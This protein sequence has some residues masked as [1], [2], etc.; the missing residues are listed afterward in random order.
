MGTPISPPRPYLNNIA[1]ATITSYAGDYSTQRRSAAFST[2][3]SRLESLLYPLNFGLS[4]AV[5]AIVGQDDIGP[6]QFNSTGRIAWI[7]P[8]ELRPPSSPLCQRTSRSPPPDPLRRACLTRTILSPRHSHSLCR[9]HRPS[10]SVRRGRR[11]DVTPADRRAQPESPLAAIEPAGCC[12][13][14]PGSWIAVPV[15]SHTVLISLAIARRPRRWR[16]G[17]SC[18]PAPSV[19]MPA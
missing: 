10:L 1:L 9:D 14:I 3:V 17:A 16:P 6:R 15:L 8:F 13:V 2:A 5:L 19:S 4:T 7:G 11:P 12:I 18:W